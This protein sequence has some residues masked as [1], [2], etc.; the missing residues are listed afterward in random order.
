MNRSNEAPFST[1]P[2]ISGDDNFL[3]SYHPAFSIF[4]F[5][6]FHR[7][8]SQV[9]AQVS[10]EWFVKVGESDIWAKVIYHFSSRT[11]YSVPPFS[12]HSV[13]NIIS[14]LASGPASVVHR[15]CQALLKMPLIKLWLAGKPG[16][17]LSTHLLGYPCIS[18]TSTLRCF[19]PLNCKQSLM[20]IF[21]AYSI[22]R[23]SS[24]VP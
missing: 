23:F 22:D 20:S 19:I 18:L 13:T 10:R 2:S 24:A 11:S 12:T 8:S 14:Y 1:D 21:F 9:N 6:L 7:P 17:L 5:Y 15:L 16:E 3:L 4:E